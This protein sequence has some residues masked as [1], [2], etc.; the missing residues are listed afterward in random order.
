MQLAPTPPPLPVIKT[1]G[2][3]GAGIGERQNPAKNNGAPSLCH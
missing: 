1:S 2:E 3:E